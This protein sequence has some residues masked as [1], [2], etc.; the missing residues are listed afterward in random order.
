MKTT[1]LFFIAGLMSATSLFSQS[2][3]DAIKQTMNEQFEPADASFKALIQSNPGN[4]EF[5][6]YY[7][8]NYFKNGNMDMANKMYQKGVDMNATN[9][10][11]YVGLGKVQWYQGK[12]ADAKANFFK[13]TTLA[14][15]KNATVLM[16]IADAYINAPTK[17]LADAFTLLDQAAK[18][19]PKNPA[20]IILTGDAYLEQNNGSKAIEYYEKA[21]AL[22]PKSVTAILCQGKLYRRSQ[23]Y[24]LALEFYKKAS[25]ID[26][27]FAPAYREKAE[28]YFLAG[29]NKNASAQY[30]KYLELNPNCDAK[31]RCAG[32]LEEAKLY[33][34][35]VDLTKE[36]LKC[37]PDTD[38]KKVYLYRYLSFDYF[39]LKNYQ[40]GKINSDMFFQKVTPDVKLIPQDYE[41]RAK[42]NSKAGNDSLAIIDYKKA[43]EMDTT[44][45]DL[46]ND[47]ANAYMNMKKYSDA[48]N[49]YKKKVDNKTA[50]K[51]DYYGIGKAYYFSK[52]F[53]NAD[54]SFAQ[55]SRL[56]TA[57]YLGYLW[58]AKTNAQIDNKNEKWLAKPY[59]EKFV[60]KLKPEEKDNVKNYLIDAYTYLG[61]NEATH[62]EYCKAKTFFTLISQLDATNANAKK[63]LESAEAKK[64]P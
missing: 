41:Y 29:Q 32:I 52:D 17:N 14:A 45:K 33:Q 61:A 53:V 23:N 9:P 18:L 58:R 56:D 35:S 27:S 63:F 36:A 62:K 22:D 31:V 40:D 6:F 1:K 64:C 2:L 30:K 3:S 19:E 21:A 51:A 5:Y 24:P 59:Y 60:A 26:S 4:G 10:L 12:Q 49:V 54:S 42:F 7:G 8:E 13:A 34:E 39:A 15:N 57:Y 46:N 43:M 47:I 28:I 50:T 16:K 25:L 55:L 11:P 38:P 48:I 20:V 37:D 44:R